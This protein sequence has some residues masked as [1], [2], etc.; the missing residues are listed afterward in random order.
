MMKQLLGE[1]ICMSAVRIPE[2]GPLAGVVVVDATDA[3]GEMCG[4]LLA[5]LG[6]CVLKI[7]PI[8][9][10]N[11]RRLGPFDSGDRKSLY[12]AHVGAGKHSISLNFEDATELEKL[13]NLIKRA[14]IF[15]ESS[16]L[17]YMNQLGFGYDSLNKIN[18]RLIYVSISAYGRTGPKASWPATDFTVES[19][20]GLTTLQGDG[21][22]PPVAVGY[23]Q[24]SFHAGAQA[25]TDAVIALNER[26]LSGKGQHLDVSM[27]TTMIWTLMHATGFWPMEE[28]EPPLTGDDRAAPHEFIGK[29]ELGLVNTIECL[30]GFVLATLRTGRFGARVFKMAAA[31]AKR[32][33]DLDPELRNIDW[34]ELSLQIQPDAPEEITKLISK[35]AD[36]VYRVFGRRTKAEILDR[37]VTYDAQVAPVNSI[38]DLVDRDPQLRS[39]GFWKRIGG[40]IHPDT[41]VKF[42]RTLS[43]FSHPAPNLGVHNEVLDGPIAFPSGLPARTALA[44]GLKPSTRDRDGL[45]F[46]GLKVADFSWVGVGPITAKA[47]ADHGATVVHIESASMPDV[48]RMGRPAKDGIPG[49]D[50]GQFFANFNSSKLG[51]QLNLRTPHGKR[52]AMELIDWADVVVDSFTSGTMKRLGFDPKEILKSRP[53]LIWYSTTLR[54]QTGPHASFG[55]F[56]SQGSAIAGL[57]GLTGWP[58]RAPAGTW[59]A[60]TDF[61]TPRYGV[62][63]LA[64]A[65]FERRVTGLGQFIDMAQTEAGLQFIG[66]LLLDYTTNGNMTERSGNSSF[67]ACPNGIYPTLD[68]TERYI[69]ISCETEDQWARLVDFIDPDFSFA[70]FSSR[71]ERLKHEDVINKIIADW[72]SKL[73]GRELELRLIGAGIPASVVQRTSELY[74]DDQLDHRGFFETLNHA[75]MGPTPYDGHATMFSGRKGTS[76][77][78]PGPVMGEHTHQVMTEILN[79]SEL[80][81]AEAAVSG[82]FE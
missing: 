22:R 35:A 49:L 81:I 73:N 67:Y 40:R 23:P 44:S 65:I 8:E 29:L 13:R 70:N 4:R 11:S 74:S 41:P 45:A 10:V 68:G 77:R 26:A 48:L 76:L 3:R 18:E 57:H 30:D 27:Q 43:D 17:N 61:I 69:A 37:A 53:D 2:T 63:A 59:G 5:D 14:D 62:S 51:L 25:A 82:A 16:N 54:G 58:D 20:A 38:A 56:G 78:G 19:A 36:M 34:D 64:A 21:D 32:D 31:L 1:V 52:I 24:A 72:S 79:F 71:E 60:Y 47:L 12:W 7:E 33:D 75:L 28:C 39:R 66:P 9:G 46:S 55:G 15:V 42:S 6:A 80:E 50:R